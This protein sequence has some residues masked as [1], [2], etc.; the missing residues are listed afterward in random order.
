VLFFAVDGKESFD[1]NPAL[2]S[3]LLFDL[4]LAL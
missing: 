1:D 4:A 3:A 2:R